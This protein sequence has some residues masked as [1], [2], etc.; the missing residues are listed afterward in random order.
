[1]MPATMK[2]KLKIEGVDHLKNHNP[3][4]QNIGDTLEIVTIG[5]VLKPLH[6]YQVLLAN[7]A[8]SS[9]IKCNQFTI[10]S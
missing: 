10:V 3:M 7:I 6:F 2:L 1:M 8:I 5:R 9:I 4:Q